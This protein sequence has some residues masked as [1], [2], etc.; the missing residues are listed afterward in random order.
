MCAPRC[1]YIS[2]HLQLPPLLPA[3]VGMANI[4][5]VLRI[6]KIGAS[7]CM[8]NAN[9]VRDYAGAC[10]GQ[11]REMEALPLLSILCRASRGILSV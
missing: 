2:N 5:A 1:S 6:A 7:L 11:G 10:I 4:V 3:S 9:F 8:V